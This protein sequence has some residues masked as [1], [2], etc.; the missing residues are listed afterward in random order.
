MPARGPG[1]RITITDPRGK[2]TPEILL[3]AIEELR[4]AGAEV[5]AVGDHR[6]VA[7][8]SVTSSSSGDLQVDGKK[9]C[10][11]RWSSWPSVIAT[12]SRRRPGSGAVW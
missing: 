5:M 6:L 8:S 3:N 10:P 9:S 2:L 4:D 7:S 1:I 11:T 12:P